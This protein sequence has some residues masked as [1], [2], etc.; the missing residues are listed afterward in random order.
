[1]FLV[2]LQSPPLTHLKRL[3]L[4]GQLEDGQRSTLAALR[5]LELNPWVL[6]LQ[7]RLA[8]PRPTLRVRRAGPIFGAALNLGPGQGKER[9]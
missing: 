8:P 2:S 1:M 9:G 7:R 4:V 6:L 3:F 5:L